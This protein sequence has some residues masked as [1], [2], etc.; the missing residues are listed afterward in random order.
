MSAA[1]DPKKI[2]KDLVIAI[3]DTFMTF[4]EV[5][6]LSTP[7]A[8][9]ND[10]EQKNWE[11]LFAKILCFSCVGDIKELFGSFKDIT[12]IQNISQ[13]Q[14]LYQLESYQL[15]E[16]K[17]IAEHINEDLYNSKTISER[18]NA[19]YL[20][21]HYYLQQINTEFDR[22]NQ[23]PVFKEISQLES[24]TKK[25][26]DKTE[27]VNQLIIHDLLYLIDKLNRQISMKIK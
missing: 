2:Q 16:L 24:K 8:S 18:D 20:L 6:N 10:G 15:E 13:Q 3:L 23:D 4:L 25:K 14:Y 19:I 9:D 1:I 26:F 22:L 12:Q 21:V 11:L 17:K 7:K 5:D 27:R